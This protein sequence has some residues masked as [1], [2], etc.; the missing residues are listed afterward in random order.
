MNLLEDKNNPLWES[1]NVIYC[2]TNKINGKKY[3][4]Q[5]KITLKKRH[6]A[7][8]C[9]KL[10]IDRAIKKYGVENF[11]LEILH[12]ADD[13]S[14]DLLE[15]YYIEKW[16]LLDKRYG[17]NVSS[18][19]ANGNT[20]KGK[21]E[22]E[23][24]EIRYKIGSANRGKHHSD[25][26]NKKISESLKG[27][28]SPTK[29]KKHTE[30]SKQKISESQKI[31]VEQY[32]KDNKLIKTWDSIKEAQESLGIYGISSCCQFWNI[33]CDKNEWFKIHKSYPHKSAGGFIWKYVKED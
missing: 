33:N 20:F 24:I 12:F 3:V 11:T 13:Y 4:G 2:Y 6:G 10:V 22:E 9:R 5:T 14:I 29:G 17:Y 23:M 18:G 28:E 25:E 21:T 19:G 15:I 8:I 32:T 16:N 7:H 1:K 30:E 26:Q 31:K 27:R